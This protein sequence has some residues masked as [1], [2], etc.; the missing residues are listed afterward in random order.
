MILG[1]QLIAKCKQ[2]DTSS[3]TGDDIYNLILSGIVHSTLQKTTKN[4]TPSGA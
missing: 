4:I 1:L 2:N 3:V